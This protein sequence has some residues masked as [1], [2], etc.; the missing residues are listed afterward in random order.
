MKK[1]T[2]IT[3]NQKSNIM[4]AQFQSR[5]YY[6]KTLPIWIKWQKTQKGQKIEKEREQ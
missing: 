6:T 3:E 1:K 2:E 5:T 4:D